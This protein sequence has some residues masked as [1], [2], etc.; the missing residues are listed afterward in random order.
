MIS[1]DLKYYD[2]DDDDYYYYY[3]YYYYCCYYC[4][5]T[6]TVSIVFSMPKCTKCINLSVNHQSINLHI[7]KVPYFRLT[8]F[9]GAAI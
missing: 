8:R 4:D 3:Y 5:T 9:K 6:E 2:D 1:R 7:Y